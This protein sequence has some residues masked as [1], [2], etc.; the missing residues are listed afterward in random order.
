ML[1]AWSEDVTLL[2][3]GPAELDADGAGQLAAAGVTLDERPVVALRGSGDKLESVSFAD[4]S[5]RRLGGL[6]VPVTLHQSTTL[7]GQLGAATVTAGPV[8]GEAVQRDSMGK[9][10]VPGLSAAG[11]LNSQMPSVANAIAAGSNGC[12]VGRPRLDGRRAR[13]RVDHV[14]AAGSAMT[15]DLLPVVLAR[16]STRPF[17]SNSLFVSRVGYGCSC[18]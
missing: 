14:R 1:R 10:S 4:G 3:D 12:C 16:A 17:V 18:N 13:A 2:S 5:E 15:C 8:S 11:D 9:T 7:A 6:L